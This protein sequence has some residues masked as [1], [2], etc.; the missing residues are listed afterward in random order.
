MSY[1]EMKITESLHRDICALLSSY[2]GDFR[3]W[4]DANMEV[5]SINSI[6]SGTPAFETIEDAMAYRTRIIKV[7]KDFSDA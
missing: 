4:L 1:K 5:D 6:T 2:E 3:Y 7:L